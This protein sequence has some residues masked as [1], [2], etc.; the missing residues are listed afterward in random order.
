MSLEDE[1]A[2]LGDLQRAIAER[3]AEADAEREEAEE[4]VTS[5]DVSAAKITVI[6]GVAIA[7]IGA[8][9]T[10]STVFLN[11]STPP[12]DSCVE[13]RA[14][15]VQLVRRT[16][17]WTELPEDSELDDQC[18]IDAYIEK[19]REDHPKQSAP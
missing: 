6:G 3:L 10:L 14:E 8:A 12:I 9:V 15:A 13:A 16:G 11:D 5:P 7:L 17:T 19:W 1:L 18:G 4:Q 2:D